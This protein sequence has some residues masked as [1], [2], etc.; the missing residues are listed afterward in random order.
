ME[1]FKNKLY[2]TNQKGERLPTR[3]F[4]YWCWKPKVILMALE[5]INFGDYLIYCDIGFEFNAKAKDTLQKLFCDIEANEI[6]GSI[7]DYPEKEWNKADL[8]AHFGLLEDREFLES[9]QC[10][11]GIVL[12]KKTQKTIQ[13]MQ[14]WLEVFYKHFELIDDSPS[15]IPNLP[16]FRENRHDQSVWSVL[17]KKYKVKNYPYRKW[18][19]QSYSVL[20]N[21][22]KIYLP[23]SVEQTKAL[24]EAV[25]GAGRYS[26]QW[27]LQ[28][29][30]RSLE[31]YAK[32]Y[33]N[34]I[35]KDEVE[36][37]KFKINF[38][39][40]KH[41]IHNH[42]AYKLG[43]AMILNSKSFLGYIRMPYVLSYIK[44]AH[45]KEI[46]DYEKKV[47]KNPKLKLPKLESYADYKEALK[48]KECFTYK[49][50]LA[51]MEAYKTWYKGGYLRFFFQEI[52]KL[53][54]TLKEKRK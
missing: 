19:D 14:E 16:E 25:R 12:L 3:G 10:A 18:F 4:G 23:A 44:E 27:N 43:Q 39:T 26:F 9:G 46:A 11:A 54:R 50:G 21:R 1:Y 36:C 32:K 41:R 17:N 6:M 37:L 31:E 34:K 8:L 29:Y 53:R 2:I 47:A 49:L 42:L 45:K 28:V 5:Q 52:P 13:I 7:T 38:G 51:L 40:A 15:T 20:Y 33:A 22:N 24:N 48:E 30:Q 35:F